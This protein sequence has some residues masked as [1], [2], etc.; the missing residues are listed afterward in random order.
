MEYN[1]GDIAADFGKL[2]F[3]ASV[4]SHISSPDVIYSLGLVDEDI[5]ITD[6]D[7]DVTITTEEAAIGM[8]SRD[9]VFLSTIHDI[10]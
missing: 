7:P 6:K 4:S 8:P 3:L 1:F 2:L 10:Q 9:H 5:K